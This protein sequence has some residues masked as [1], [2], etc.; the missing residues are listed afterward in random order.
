[1]DTL[2][3][4][5]ATHKHAHD[6]HLTRWFYSRAFFAL[7]FFGAAFVAMVPSVVDFDALLD[8]AAGS[9]IRRVVKNVR[10]VATNADEIKLDED[11]TLV[12]SAGILN[13]M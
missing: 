10:R 8:A 3:G 6:Y 9:W 4:T 5:I 11:K 7:A 13:A 1:L 2:L 12:R